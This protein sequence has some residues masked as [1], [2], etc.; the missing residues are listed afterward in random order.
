MFRDRL[1]PALPV[2]ILPQRRNRP[3]HRRRTY[4]A[5]PSRVN[6]DCAELF[7]GRGEGQPERINARDISPPDQDACQVAQ[8]GQTC[9]IPPRRA[10][11]PSSPGHPPRP[12]SLCTHALKY[13]AAKE[14]DTEFHRPRSAAQ[15]Q[16]GVTMA[17]RTTEEVEGGIVGADFSESAREDRQLLVESGGLS[18]SKRWPRTDRR[19]GISY[20]ET[21]GHVVLNHVYAI[22]TGLK[23]SAN[24]AFSPKFMTPYSAFALTR[25]SPFVG[26]KAEIDLAGATFA[27]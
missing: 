3:H 18:R 27:I 25:I 8:A 2:A 17:A 9:A 19:P 1:K 4:R 16:A 12:I 24:H 23:R 21:P 22:R 7:D 5:A 20:H 26:R 6:V 14:E 10:S 11:G 15:I 13:F